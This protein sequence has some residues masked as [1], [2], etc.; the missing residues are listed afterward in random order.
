M[1][2]EKIVLTTRPEIITAIKTEKQRLLESSQRIAAF[3]QLTIESETVQCLFLDELSRQK[4]CI[5]NILGMIKCISDFS[6]KPLHIGKTNLDIYIKLTINKFVIDTL[7]SEYSDSMWRES[8]SRLSV[9]YFTEYKRLSETI[10]GNGNTCNFNRETFKDFYP[11]AIHRTVSGFANGYSKVFQL[12]ATIYGIKY[13][14]T[15]PEEQDIWKNIKYFLFE[16]CYEYNLT[17]DYIFKYFDGNFNPTGN[18]KIPGEFTH[19]VINRKTYTEIRKSLKADY[20]N[21]NLEKYTY[22]FELL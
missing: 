9:D 13:E 7:K 4:Y 5:A 2:K 12:L 6:E 20:E 21:E 11:A 8:C 15:N 14:A 19:R 10:C 1:S 17:G 18:D 3:K 16:N 22:S